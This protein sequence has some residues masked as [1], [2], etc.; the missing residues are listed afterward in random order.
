[1]KKTLAAAITSALVIG[2]ASTTFA[3]ANPFSDVPSN[4]WAFDAVA[5]L[6]QSGVIEGYGDG[7]FQGN[8]A[9]TRY[10][11][12]QMVAKAMAKGDK[13]S[14]SDR[15]TV[16]K[17]E[18]EYADELNS[19]GVRVANLEERSDN[20]KF[21]GMARFRYTDHQ[22][23]FKG[24]GEEESSRNL[25][26]LRLNLDAKVNDDWH[27]KARIE[28]AHNLSTNDGGADDSG[29]T[30]NRVYVEGPLFGATF[31]GGKLPVFSQQGFIVDDVVSGGQFEWSNDRWTTTLTGGR[32]EGDHWGE[33]VYTYIDSNGNRRF[34]RGSEGVDY[35]SA[36]FNYKATENLNLNAGYYY[37]SDSYMA[38]YGPRYIHS[39]RTNNDDSVGIWAIGG[40][41]KFANDWKLEGMY[42][43]SNVDN[44]QKAG[45]VQVSYK[46]AQA[47]VV[48]SYGIFAAYR[49]LGQDATIAPTYDG[50][51]YGERGYE[52]GVDYTFDKNIVGS[53]KYFDGEEIGTDNDASKFF[54]QVEF[55]F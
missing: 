43:D 29:F 54:G 28:G 11:M 14:P 55:Y 27:V 23:D 7:T 6:A 1:M 32:Y 44:G 15:D 39:Y 26:L 31:R 34:D 50:V 46:G 47:D 37:L 38:S 13:L 36:E 18:I 49:H 19:L 25:A 35:Y 52:I 45:S 9:I 30:T 21:D 2:V 53:L 17:L 12:A 10:E 22:V 40:D 24:G 42:A 20:V 3:A 51:G 5:K 41:W 48:G 4:H 33:G 8:K 16:R